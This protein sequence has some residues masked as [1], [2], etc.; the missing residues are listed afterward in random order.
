MNIDIFF[1][2]I[3]SLK[4]LPLCNQC[5]GLLRPD[6]VWSGE[7]LNERSVYSEKLVKFLKILQ[8]FFLDIGKNFFKMF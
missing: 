3:V 2:E 7:P 1:R 4:S 5:N 8:L 6:V